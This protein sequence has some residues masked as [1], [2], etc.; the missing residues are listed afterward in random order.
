MDI[1]GQRVGA[2]FHIAAIKSLVVG[3]QQR[4]Q[5]LVQ[6]LLPVVDVGVVKKQRLVVGRHAR[7]PPVQLQGQP[8]YLVTLVDI[9]VVAT[10]SPAIAG[11]G[12]CRTGHDAVVQGQFHLLG[13]DQGAHRGA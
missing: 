8:A 2:P 5:R 3:L 11:K 13:H 7:L 10:Q 6:W 12:L 1:A 4:V 9:A